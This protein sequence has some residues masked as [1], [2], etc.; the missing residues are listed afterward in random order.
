[1]PRVPGPFFLVLLALGAS[2][3]SVGRISAVQ[4]ALP[5]ERILDRVEAGTLRASLRNLTGGDS[6]ESPLSGFRQGAAL[7][8]LYRDRDYSPVFLGSR[9][10]FEAASR[11]MDQL[12]AGSGHGFD[13]ARLDTAAIGAAARSVPEVQRGFF[14]RFRDSGDPGEIARAIARVDLLLADRYLDCAF[15]LVGAN[16][17]GDGG[18]SR[19]DSVMAALRNPPIPDLDSFAPRHPQYRALMTAWTT[20]R[21]VVDGGGWPSIAEG[22]TVRPG[23]TGSRVRQIRERLDAEDRLLGRATAVVADPARYGADLKERVRA[24]QARHALDQDGAVGKMTLAALNVSAAE[25][26]RQIEITM[27]RWRRGPRDN[28]DYRVEANIPGMLAF[29]Y[30]DNRPVLTL[31]TVVGSGKTTGVWKGKPSI[32]ETPELEDEIETIVVNPRWYVPESIVRNELKAS[33]AKKPG[34]LDRGGY[35]WYDAKTGESGPAS[36]VPDSVWTDP[37]SKLRIR[38]QPGAANALGRLKF[39]FPNRHAVYMHDTPEKRLFARGRRNFS[40]GCVRVENPAQ[41]AESLLVRSSTKPRKSLDRM[42][43]S[44][45]RVTIELT[46][47]VPIHLL[48]RTVWVQEDGRIDFL[49]DLYGWDETF[50]A[51]LT[52]SAGIESAEASRKDPAAADGEDD[53]GADPVSP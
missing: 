48:Y 45:E 38:Q 46:P 32:A 20:Y 8:E 16:I 7:G 53:V 47:P 42:L 24:F 14:S 18:A 23:D 49:P 30:H 17:T 3:L 50:A 22:G 11:L 44:S 33:D 37:A 52:L 4:A 29:L 15:E 36:E 9:S 2:S 13:P 34:Y 41:L 39:L 5:A 6:G 35:E 26:L 51:D 19:R 40:H 1:M 25:R 12:G 21:R 31:N 27:A 10:S 43:A 28:P